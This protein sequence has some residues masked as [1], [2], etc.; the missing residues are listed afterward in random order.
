MLDDACSWELCAICCTMATRSAVVFCVSCIRLPACSA[1]CVPSTTWL[2]ASFMVVT[3]SAVSIW[4]LL[5]SV[6]ISSVASRALSARRCTSSAT[7][8]KPRPASP[9]DA[10]CMLAL[11]ARMCVRSAMVLMRLTTRLISWERSPSRL[12]RFSVSRMVSRIAV[13][14]LTV[15][16]TVSCAATVDWMARSAASLQ[17]RASSAILAM[18][19]A[20]SASRAEVMLT[21]SCSA[22]AAVITV[23][24][25]SFTRLEVRATSNEMSST[26]W[27]TF[28]I[29]K[30]SRLS[31]SAT[32]PVTSSVTGTFTVRSLWLS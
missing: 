1:R 9:A 29:S 11:S 28:D 6:E 13:M 19:S 4:M 3:V 8:T 7:T 17:A 18:D 24:D 26:P 23:S 5:T 22:L 21:C 12:M 25:C 20:A 2:M 10:A 31:E 16:A 30:V 15:S 27:S 14:P 32:G